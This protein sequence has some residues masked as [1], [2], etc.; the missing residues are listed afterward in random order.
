VPI[1]FLIRLFG[2]GVCVRQGYR[3]VVWGDFRRFD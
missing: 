3:F 2:N 1:E